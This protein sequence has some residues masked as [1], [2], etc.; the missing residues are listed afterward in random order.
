MCLWLPTDQ[1]IPLFDAVVANAWTVS[2]LDWF[3][4]SREEQP[5]PGQVLVTAVPT[6]VFQLVPDGW[7]WLTKGDE[8]VHK[9]CVGRIPFGWGRG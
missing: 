3:A 9:A 5:R 2:V 4:K 8:V 1:D 6:E 7:L